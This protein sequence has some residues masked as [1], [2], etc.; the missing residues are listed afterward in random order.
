V[1]Q[2]S[3]PSRLF[4]SGQRGSAATLRPWAHYQPRRLTRD[5]YNA[6]RRQLDDLDA[7]LAS[8]RQAE[9]ESRR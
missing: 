1:D 2:P 6:L 9:R 4:T 7:K 5:E 3:K 8:L